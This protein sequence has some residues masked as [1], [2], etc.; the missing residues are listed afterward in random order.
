MHQLLSF[1]GDEMRNET[2]E[3]KLDADCTHEGK[4]CTG[5]CECK[6]LMCAMEREPT[7]DGCRFG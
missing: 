7:E 5:D 6:C 3:T 4:A 2:K 1:M